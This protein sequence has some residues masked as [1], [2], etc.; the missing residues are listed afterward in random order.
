MNKKIFSLLLI[1]VAI[2]S[3]AN[4]N[5]TDNMTF[6]EDNSLFQADEIDQNYDVTDTYIAGYFENQTTELLNH[7]SIN[8]N[9]KNV[10]INDEYGEWDYYLSTFNKNNVEY[11]IIKVLPTSGVYAD[12]MSIKFNQND[13]DVYDGIYYTLDNNNRIAD[14]FDVRN[15]ELI[16]GQYYHYL[17]FLGEFYDIEYSPDYYIINNECY[18]FV[19]AAGPFVVGFFKNAIEGTDYV[20]N[21]GKY[22]YLNGSI[23]DDFLT[24]YDTHLEENE[25]EAI[26]NGFY[27]VSDDGICYRMFNSRY[28]SPYEYI[29]INETFYRIVKGEG[30]YNVTETWGGEQYDILTNNE[31]VLIDG[32]LYPFRNNKISDLP[33]NLSRQSDYV[34]NVSNVSKYFKGP[35]RFVV[36]INDDNGNPVSN[37]SIKMNINGQDYIRNTDSYGQASIPLNLNPAIYDV[38]TE[39]NGL[40]FFSTVNINPTIVSNDLTKIFRNATQYQGKFTDSQGNILK[41][42][43]VDFN[44][45]GVLYTRNTGEDGVAGLNI[46]L[47]PGEYIITATNPNST[48]MHSN[49]I[50]VLPNIVENYDL[51]KYYKNDSQYVIRLLD[52]KGNPAGAGETVEFN[53]NGVFYKRTSNETGHVKMNINLNPGTYIITANYKGLM[54]AN[55]ITVK[56]I[57]EASD[58]SMHYRDGSKFKSTLLDS[59]G[60]PLANKTVTFNI[61]GVFYNRTTDSDGVA[62]LNINLMAGEYIITSMYEN[63][64]A[65]ANKVTVRS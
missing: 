38:V 9:V 18:K 34:I 17:G 19:G 13:Y 42:T 25:S 53:I 12:I 52:D 39:V 15:Y 60:N 59:Q 41:N 11:T 23:I 61:N 30:T 51:T 24:M 31:Y 55:I 16:D 7:D 63:G 50:K 46:N 28:Y 64:A 58:L 37:I 3:I 32:Q 26:V 56:P 2:F 29:K 36:T 10:T 5:A 49:I 43:P 33:L 54:A 1:L 40:E 48:E 20:I 47:N 8:W 57:L 4:V 22:Y 6:N 35:E 21:D 27:L 45:N 14:I 62:S 65:I 44:I